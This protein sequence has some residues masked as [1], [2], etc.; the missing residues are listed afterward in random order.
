MQNA[1]ADA[2]NQ[3]PRLGAGESFA[4]VPEAAAFTVSV[5]DACPLTATVAGLRLHVIWLDDGVQA[6][7]TVPL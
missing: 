2:G 5:V 4:D 1:R 6:R 7:L 3:P